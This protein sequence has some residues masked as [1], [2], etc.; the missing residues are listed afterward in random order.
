MDALEESAKGAREQDMEANP[1]VK[2]ILFCDNLRDKAR[3]FLKA[4]SATINTMNMQKASK[5][6]SSLGSVT[7]EWFELWGMQHE[8]DE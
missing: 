5:E 3:R 2:L 4:R 1:A 6:S 7:R 8:R